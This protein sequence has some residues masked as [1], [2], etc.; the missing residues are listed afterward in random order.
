[1]IDIGVNLLSGQYDADRNAV[2]QRARQS[3]LSALVVTASDLQ[4]STAAQVFC[5]EHPGFLFCTAG[6]HPHQAD[7]VASQP[8][9]L[10]LPQ[11]ARL[12]NSDVVV[13]LGEMGLDYFR[14]FATA[15]NQRRVLSAQ[16]ALAAE[17]QMPVF[18]HDRDAS[19][20]M[21][22]LLLGSG[23]EPSS[24]VIHCFTGDAKALS[25]YL[26]MGCMI[27][28]TGWLCDRKRGAML[29]ELV[30]RIPLDR[31]LIETDG[32]YLKPHN[33]PKQPFPQAQPQPSSRRNEP[34]LL[35][36]VVQALADATGT[37]PLELGAAT[38][39]NAQRL[40]P[41]LNVQRP[42]RAAQTELEQ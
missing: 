4:E 27:G 19:A 22:E 26:D 24:V 11:I 16:L 17:L 23:V 32:P 5:L 30:A 21:V 12:C 42:A 28:I 20:D 36:Y 1:M 14:N 3:G 34:A 7:A 15:A 33:A 8:A 13:A 40:F 37:T 18:A 29:R 10:W 39:S 31:L 41:K 9:E 2:I 6:V 25:K 38:S 35:A